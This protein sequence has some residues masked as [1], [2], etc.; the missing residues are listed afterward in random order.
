MCKS[1]IVKNSKKRSYKSVFLLLFFL[2]DNKSNLWKHLIYLPLQK[3]Q[4][5]RKSIKI[6]FEAFDWKVTEHF[7]IR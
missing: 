3:E 7:L 2:P 4:K 1:N 6:I 5:K